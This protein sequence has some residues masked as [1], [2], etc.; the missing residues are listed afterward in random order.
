MS[1]RG[2]TE[3][4]TAWESLGPRVEHPQPSRA[5]QASGTRP[6]RLGCHLAQGLVSLA[7]SILRKLWLTILSLYSLFTSICML[8]HFTRVQLFA[9]LWT[10]A[11]HAPLPMG[12]S[13]QE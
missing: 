7:Q 13:R 9:T 12:D 6:E 10:V 1:A 5:W 3:C 4:R 11:R 8:S 2:N